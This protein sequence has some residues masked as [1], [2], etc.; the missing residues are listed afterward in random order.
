M[1]KSTVLKQLTQ[2]KETKAKMAIPGL[3]NAR[4]V[5]SKVN[6]KQVLD[7]ALFSAALY[8]MYYFG[9][10]ISDSLEEQMPSEKNVMEM[11]KQAGAAPGLPP[12]GL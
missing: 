10:T 12:P 3:E 8:T 7:I 5:L 6:K 4:K 2:G 1:E 11:M 9:K